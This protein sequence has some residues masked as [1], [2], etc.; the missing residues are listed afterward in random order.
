MADGETPLAGLL[1]RRIALDGPITIADFMALALGH[2]RHGYYMTR[3]PLGLAG[4]FTTAPEV[5][6]MMGELVGLWL[7][8]VWR[9]MG[10]PDPVRLVEF[11][12]G[13]GTLMADAL[14]AA[15]MMPGFREALRVTLIETSPALQAAQR[16]MLAD[17]TVPIDWAE[18][19]AELPAEETPLLAIGNEL[20]DALP[21]RQLQRTE[22]GWRERL[23]AVEPETDRLAFAL[24][25]GPGPAEA[26]LPPAV[27]ENAGTGS[28]AEVAP[29]AWAIARDL[30]ERLAARGGAALF[31]DY[32]HEASA[33]GD[34]LQAVRAHE[35][36]DPLAHIGE[37]DVTAHVD[38]EQL[39]RAFAEAGC[40]TAPLSTQGAFL[41]VL[42]IHQRAHRLAMTGDT[43]V[44]EAARDR[45]IG[46]S[47]NANG[48]MGTLFKVLGVAAPGTPP[49]P[50]LEG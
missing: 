6:Q 14:R 44:I 7:A 3:D 40:R 23:V 34:T 20:F 50:G 39:A 10:A 32:G 12:P 35:Y 15:K 30:G 38:F 33:A 4:D 18:G 8:E 22:D 2:P 45:L 49:L 27:R 24:A 19:L 37:A 13:R 9:Q 21:I 1:K 29:A 36:C 28:V 31:I 17:E 25:P 41:T 11:G 16:R 43:D 47:L 42:G 48:G 46:D 26:L 5:S